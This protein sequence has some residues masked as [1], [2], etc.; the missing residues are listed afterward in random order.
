VAWLQNSK[1]FQ[2]HIGV[3]SVDKLFWMVSE[4][5]AVEIAEL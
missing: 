5:L 3:H 4:R 2:E 1:D